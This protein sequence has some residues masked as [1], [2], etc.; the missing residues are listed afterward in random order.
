MQ[1]ATSNNLISV[2][3]SQQI[4]DVILKIRWEHAHKSVRCLLQQLLPA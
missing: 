3:V 1:I 4:H 2:P